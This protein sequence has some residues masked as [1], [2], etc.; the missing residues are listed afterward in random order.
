MNVIRTVCVVA[1]VVLATVVELIVPGAN[2]ILELLISSITAILT[3]MLISRRICNG[4]IPIQR[5]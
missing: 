3:G 4:P 1:G 2:F 5:I